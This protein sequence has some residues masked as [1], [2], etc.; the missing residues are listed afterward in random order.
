[1]NLDKNTR[2]RQA[3]RAAIEGSVILDRMLGNGN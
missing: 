2:F 3:R 1:M